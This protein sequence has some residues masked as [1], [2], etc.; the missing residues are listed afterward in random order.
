MWFFRNA[1]HVGDGGLL[2]RIRA[3]LTA[4]YATHPE[5][6]VRRAPQPAAPPTAVWINPPK[7]TDENE[8]L[9]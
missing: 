2:E 4:A 9:Q 1:L 8:A 6:F 3:I 7:R 5:R